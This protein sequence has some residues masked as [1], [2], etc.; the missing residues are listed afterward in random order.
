MLEET[1]KKDPLYK[2]L[3]PAPFQWLYRGIVSGMTPSRAS[4]AA[5]SAVFRF[6]V[7]AEKGRRR[8][9]GGSL[10]A[11]RH[12]LQRSAALSAA[13][14][15]AG[16]PQSPCGGCAPPEHAP[17]VRSCLSSVVTASRRSSS[18]APVSCISL[19]QKPVV[20]VFHYCQ[21]RRATGTYARVLASSAAVDQRR[22]GCQTPGCYFAIFKRPELRRAQ[23]SVV[24][25]S[26]RVEG[27]SRWERRAIFF[28][29]V[30]RQ[31][32][33]LRVKVLTRRENELGSMWSRRWRHGFATVSIPH[34]TRA[35]AAGGRDGAAA[36]HGRPGRAGRAPPRGGEEEG[37]PRPIHRPKA[38]PTPP[39]GLDRHLSQLI[40]LVEVEVHRDERWRASPQSHRRRPRVHGSAAVRP[41]LFV[42][43]A[44]LG[45]SQ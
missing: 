36:T 11:R 7:S 25:P 43:R 6:P 33:N 40:H 24:S 27:C 17:R 20:S 41:P 18:V 10:P 31:C 44:C 22:R 39:V 45:R 2:F 13:R 4:G 30:V 12:V 19:P 5:R 1:A 28:D 34:R 16:L 3:S 35:A 26:A 42:M 37:V 23:G 32:A 29:A 14:A 15:F 21:D 9:A 8:R 38:T